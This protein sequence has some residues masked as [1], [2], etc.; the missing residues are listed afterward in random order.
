MLIVLAALA[1]L[2][3]QAHEHP[4]PPPATASLLDAA[5]RAG[6]SRQHR[7]GARPG[8]YRVERGARSTTA[9]WLSPSYWLEAARCFNAALK[10]DPRW[11]SCRRSCR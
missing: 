11:P 2:A 8:R 5:A 1:A 10:V 3:Q 7:H 4:A 6:G 9:G